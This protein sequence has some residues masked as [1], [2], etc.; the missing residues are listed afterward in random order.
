[1]RKARSVLVLVL[2]A[3]L[4]ISSVSGCGSDKKESKTE[5]KEIKL[6]TRKYIKDAEKYIELADYKEIS[7]KKLQIEE[8][9]QKD[10]DEQ[11]SAHV[12]YKK[13]KKG[14]VKKGDTVNIYYVGKVDGKEFEG[15][16][17]T[18][19]TQPAG[20]DLTIG[21]GTFI[22]GFEDGLIGKKIGEVVD[23]D[24]TFPE[25]YPQNESLAGKKAVFTVTINAKQGKKIT[26]VFDDAFVKEN[27]DGYDTAKEYKQETRKSIVRSMA[28]EQVTKATKV[29][30]YPE[31]IM[32]EAKNQNTTYI[33][34]MLSQQGMK[35]DDYLEQIGKTEEDFEK[36]NDES[37]KENVRYQLTYHA[38]AQK[39]GIKATEEEYKDKLEE[40]IANFG[41]KD[42]D[43]M[44]K[45][46]KQIYGVEI[47]TIVYNDIYNNKVADLLV[48]YVKEV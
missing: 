38:I 44:R 21:S 37:A 34:Y 26:P 17:C 5:E 3:V 29:K 10:I 48:D 47:T 33:E 25:N 18:K 30:E 2:C 40:Y 41:A 45:Q 4:T 24:T 36:D 35:F 9:L 6:E 12:T 13:I 27:V 46:F 11:L 15:G 32:A 28:I 7:L 19:E 22:E 42:E 16:S 20:Y 8:E 23:V 43:D 14:T 31:T 39:E 1:M